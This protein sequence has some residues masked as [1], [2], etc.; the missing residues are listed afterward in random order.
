VAALQVQFTL[1]TPANIQ[2][3]FIF[4]SVEFPQFT[5]G[6]T[7][8]F[9]AFLDGTGTANQITF[10]NANN[11]V[12]VGS[13][14]VM[15]LTTADTNTAF[16]NPHGLISNLTTISPLL[17]AGAHTLTFE[18]GDVN[19]EILDSAAFITNLSVCTPPAGT[20]TCTP[21]TNPGG[22]PEPATLVLLSIGLAGLAAARRWR[23]WVV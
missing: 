2:F 5:N 11:P 8:A 13:S 16:A 15:A 20:Q 22:V 17:A 18:V 3:S 9:L 4:G 1:A 19:D 10:D 14:F 12:Q 23:K 7:D 21:G 6:F